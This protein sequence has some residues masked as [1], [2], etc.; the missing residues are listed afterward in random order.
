MP[1]RLT[2]RVV[3]SLPLGSKRS[4]VFDADLPG[5]GVSVMPTGK[6]SFFVQYRTPGGRRGQKRR[7]KI[8]C[9]GRLTVEEART[10]AK[11]LLADVVQG[12]DPAAVLKSKKTNPTMRELGADYL[13]YVLDRRKPSTA[14]EYR[15]M[16]ER[17]ILP[18]FGSMLVE[19]V[20]PAMIGQLHRRMK[21]TPYLA[22]R[23]LALLGSF[24]SYSERQGIR[25]RH[26]NPTL[27]IEP[28][29]E[30]S[31]E[32]FLTPAEVK[33]LGAALAEAEKHGLPAAPNRK[34]QPATGPTTK[35]RPKAIGVQPAN[36]FAIAAIRFLLL[37]GFRER[38]ALSLRWT[39]V[40]VARQVVVLADSKTGRSVRRIG[41]AATELL[42]QLPKIDGS[43]YVFPG[44]Q[45]GRHLVEINRVWYAARFAAELDDV[46]L[47]DLRHSFASAV[48]SAGGSLLM[49]RNL[50]GHKMASTTAKYAHLLADPVQATADAT[51]S[52]LAE[53]LA[54]KGND[55][56]RPIRAV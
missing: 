31:R 36:P 51:A 4:Y 28:Y 55:R 49:I 11:R 18:E 24:F 17:H 44:S 38:E 52:G 27:D 48:A 45:R 47:H 21:R 41:A 3:D 35:H 43:P 37:T 12:A 7:V 40:D 2:K 16:W 15:R 19:N 22:N 33:R 32:R 9:Y 46:R 8:G 34:R 6:R 14:R 20:M 50:L 29:R 25:P 26:S 53:L 13:E 1:T 39:E 10:A 56:I 42:S 54:P 30:Q 5:F 23:V